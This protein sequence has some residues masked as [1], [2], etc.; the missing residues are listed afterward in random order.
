MSRLLPLPAVNTQVDF[1][2]VLLNP[3]GSQT[4]AVSVPTTTSRVPSSANNTNPTIAKASAGVL[5][6]VNGYNSTATVTYLKFYN[7]AGAPVVG[8]TPVFLTLALPP[9]SVFAYDLD[10]VVFATGIA[11]G[12]TTDATDAG[13]TAVAAGAI[14]GLNVVFS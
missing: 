11:Y 13:T 6:H 5:F 3:D 10:G 8:T 9:T 2:A 1:T 7:T 12:L 4:A 14:L